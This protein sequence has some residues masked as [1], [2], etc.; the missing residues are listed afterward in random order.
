[1]FNTKGMSNGHFRPELVKQ[2]K[3]VIDTPHQKCYRSYL[4]NQ[5]N[6]KQIN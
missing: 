1:M 2:N 6:N 3:L 4:H 5:Q